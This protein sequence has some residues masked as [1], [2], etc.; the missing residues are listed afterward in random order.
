MRIKWKVNKKII[1]ITNKE[2]IKKIEVLTR[3]LFNKINKNFHK[4]HHKIHIK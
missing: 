3:I 4:I 2:K 1:N